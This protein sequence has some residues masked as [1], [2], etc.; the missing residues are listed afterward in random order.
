LSPQNGPSTLVVISVRTDD[1]ASELLSSIPRQ[2]RSTPHIPFSPPPQAHAQPPSSPRYGPR[3]SIGD[4]LPPPGPVDDILAGPS[5][6]RTGYGVE[7]EEEDDVL[8]EDEFQL[9]KSYYDMKEFDR[10]VWT[11]RDAQGKRARFLRI[12]SSYLVRPSYD[13]LWFLPSS[14]QIG[15]LKNNCLIF[16]IR[17]KS[18]YSC[19]AH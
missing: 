17:N 18:G 3:P 10:V 15:K 12:Y 1:R 14:H 8:D 6:A 7:I 2:Y 11:L 4:F 19:L 5:R 13:Y 9:A 16:W